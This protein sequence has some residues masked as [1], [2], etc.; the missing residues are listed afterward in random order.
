MP[1]ILTTFTTEIQHQN[2]IPHFLLEPLEESSHNMKPFYTFILVLAH[3]R[4]SYRMPNFV[5]KL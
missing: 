2:V 4:I 3:V 5:I 1:P